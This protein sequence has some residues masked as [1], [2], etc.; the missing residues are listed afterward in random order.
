MKAH[1]YLFPLR[2]AAM[3]GLYEPRADGTWRLAL[4]LPHGSTLSIVSTRDH[5]GWT[6]TVTFGYD[7]ETIGG[8]SKGVHTD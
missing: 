1:Q 7:R 8:S 3:K 2:I 5:R 6:A 4:K